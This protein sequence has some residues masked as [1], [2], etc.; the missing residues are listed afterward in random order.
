MRVLELRQYTL[1]P[2]RRDELIELFDRELVEPQEALGMQ[3]VGTFR[4]LD[5]ADRFIWLRAFDD[6]A[7][8]G[9]ALS[10]FY[11]GP[12]WTTHSSQANATMVDSDNVLLLSPVRDFPPMAPRP[13]LG[14]MQ[15]PETLITATIYYRDQPFEDDLVR[16]I[17]TLIG[18]EAIASFR[19]DYAENTFP[20]LPVRAGEHAFVWF[21][22]NESPDI[23]PE[24]VSSTE[25]L[26]L[27]PTARSML[28]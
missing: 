6:M 3:I 23:A 21:S 20:A 19:T 14:H 8:R 7:G 9:E 28:R 17:D 1:L 26:R 25:R 22:D 5:D 15:I 27:S 24:S 12:A 2:G 11:T 18:P 13:P 16:E 4:D 10:A